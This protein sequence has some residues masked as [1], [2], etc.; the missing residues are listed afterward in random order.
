MNKFVAL[1]VGA[2]FSLLASAANAAMLDG[3]FA[4]SQSVGSTVA[5]VDAGNTSTTLGLAT[6]LDFTAGGDGYNFQVTGAL[7]DF[8]GL[9]GQFGTLTDFQFSPSLSPSPLDPLWAVAG[10]E[11]V[12][13]SVTVVLQNDNALVL[14]A[15][16]T[17]EDTNGVY[18]DTPG[19]W[20]FTLNQTGQLLSFSFSTATN[21]PEPATL[22]LFGAGLLGLGM[23]R[24]R[25]A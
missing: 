4:T 25:A 16:G 20:D 21:V 23:L 12:A 11:F 18:D 1:G 9:I 13:D 6:G 8:L 2:A 17:I 7:G 15:V 22:A 24:R 5:A 3:A 19:I 14:R 10:F